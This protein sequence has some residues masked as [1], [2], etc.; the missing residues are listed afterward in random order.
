[1]AQST[2]SMKRFYAVVAIAAV[3]GVGWLLWLT[4]RPSTPSVPAAVPI[5][6]SD[7][8][9]FRGYVLGSDTAPIEIVEYADYQCPACQTYATVE[10][11]YVKERLIQT[12]R[13]RYVYKDFPLEQHQWARLA[14]HAAAC[15]DEQ[16]RFWELHEAIY[17]AHSEW[18]GSRDAGAVFRRL[19]RE[20]GLDIEAYDD[21]MRSLRHAGRIQAMAEE[22]TRLGV[23]STPTFVIGGRLYPGVMR[24]DRMRRLVDSLTATP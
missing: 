14:A 16:G 23:H 15:A 8:A 2:R 18:A 17:L 10:Q 22:G 3:G 5:Q 21:C 6:P 13:V 4:T 7:T 12:G 11:P 20:R 1:M 9:G 24:Y 19:A